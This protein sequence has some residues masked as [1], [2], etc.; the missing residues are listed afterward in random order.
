MLRFWG[1]LYVGLLLGSE[2]LPE[3][4]QTLGS[5]QPRNGL[6]TYTLGFV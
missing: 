5:S 4:Q 3:S 2:Q 1:A 6:S